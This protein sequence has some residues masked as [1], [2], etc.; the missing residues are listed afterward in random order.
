MHI[1]MD[2]HIKRK[3]QLDGASP[4]YSSFKVGK[5]QSTLETLQNVAGHGNTLRRVLQ[6]E[7]GSSHCWKYQQSSRSQGIE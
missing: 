4:L 7:V 3:G 1:S 6:K 5:I 2:G